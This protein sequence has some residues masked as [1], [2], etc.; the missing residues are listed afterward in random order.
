MVVVPAV[1]SIAAYSDQL[2]VPEG[3]VVLWKVL[4]YRRAAKAFTPFIVLVEIVCSAVVTGVLLSVPIAM[5]FPAPVGV[6]V[7][8]VL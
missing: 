5:S 2:H 6:M 3:I 4:S 1:E 8:V 7:G